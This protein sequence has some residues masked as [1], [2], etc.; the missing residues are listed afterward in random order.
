MIAYKLQQRLPLMR[1]RVLRSQILYESLIHCKIYEQIGAGA[2]RSCETVGIQSACGV[3]CSQRASFVCKQLRRSA[4]VT[5][6]HPSCWNLQRGA[7]TLSLSLS[8]SLSADLSLWVREE[9]S[10]RQ[11]SVVAPTFTPR[12]T[13]HGA[14]TNRP[15]AWPVS[16]CQ[17]TDSQ[18]MPRSNFIAV[19]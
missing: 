2:A 12:W 10:W 16:Q 8:L 14:T 15:T 1:K 19:T 5:K 9:Q 4:R 3:S 13:R 17:Q 6:R 11:W 7:R 18:L